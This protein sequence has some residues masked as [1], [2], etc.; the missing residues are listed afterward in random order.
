MTRSAASV[1]LDTIIANALVDA[2]ERILA[3][4]VA[5]N[6]ARAVTDALLAKGVLVPEDCFPTIASPGLWI[7]LVSS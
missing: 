2:T 5:E 3:P 7:P 4:S 1:T 6:L